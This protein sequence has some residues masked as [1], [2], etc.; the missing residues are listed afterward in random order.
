M[1]TLINGT[2]RPNRTIRQRIRR[3]ILIKLNAVD[4]NATANFVSKFMQPNGKAQMTVTIDGIQ[5]EANTFYIS[6]DEPAIAV[7]PWVRNVDISDCTF[8]EKTA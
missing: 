4:V 3:W 7:A 8:L 6:P 1:T 2:W 5:I